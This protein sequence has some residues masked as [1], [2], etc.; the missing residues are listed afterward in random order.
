MLLYFLRHGPAGSRAEWKGPDELR[1][2]TDDGRTMVVR[3]ADALAAADVAVNAILTSPLVRARQTAEIA[4]AALCVGD[5]SL[6]DD[7]RLA[8]GFDRQA[9]AA[10][11]AEHPKARAL[12]LVGHEPDFSRTIGQVTGGAVT[13]K[14]GGLARVDIDPATLHG[15]LT[16]L[17]P[18][19]VITMP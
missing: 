15:E 2:L 1:P 19:R 5:D 13:I 4:A 16:W 7:E 8:H 6:I 18:P 9:L 3:V 17:L 14:K 11:V 12:M 10:I